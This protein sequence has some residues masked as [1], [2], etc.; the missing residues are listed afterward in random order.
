MNRKRV[1]AYARVST[2]SRT[3]S[4]SFEFQS[5]YW[6]NKLMNDKKYEYIGLFAD[7]GISGKFTELRPQFM[8]LMDKCRKGG[9]DMIFTKSVQR[10]ARNTEEL[11]TIVRELREIGVAVIFE[12]ENINTLNPDS[13]LYLNIATA[14]AEEDL[15]RYSDNVLWAIRDRFQKGECIA[16]S[17]LFGYNVV[18]SKIQSVN[19]EEAEI[20]RIIYNRYATGK[21]SSVKIAQWLN[22]QGYV[23]PKGNKWGDTQVRCILR[24]EKYKGNAILQKTYVDRGVKKKN[25]GQKDKYYIENSHQAIVD[26]DLW[27]KV[28]TILEE[29]QNKKLVGQETKSY[30]FTSM[31]ECGICGHNFTHKVN[32]SGTPWQANFWKCRNAIQ[33]GVKVCRNSGIKESILNDLFVEC[34]NEFIEKGYMAIMER[35]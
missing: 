7:K 20:V 34:Y 13:E 6:N 33:H 5:Y 19:E 30:P 9:V 15:S 25:C 4:H 12:K 28:Q 21:E 8:A 16:G 3:Q 29:R 26:K 11:L 17:Q 23:S 10:F 14:L 1:A 2:N 18:G 31:I 27:D 24:N 32:N 35:Q 22:N